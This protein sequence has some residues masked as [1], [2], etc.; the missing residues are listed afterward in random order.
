MEYT[1]A[2]NQRQAIRKKRKEKQSSRACVLL[3]MD[4]LAQISM[5]KHVVAIED[6]ICPNRS[7]NCSLCQKNYNATL[8]HSVNHRQE[9]LLDKNDATFTQRGSGLDHIIILQVRE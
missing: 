7:N 9:P 6:Y 1:Y 3:V 5:A 2:S 8:V 4:V